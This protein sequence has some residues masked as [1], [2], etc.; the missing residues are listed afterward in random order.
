M[1]DIFVKVNG[2]DRLVEEMFFVKRGK[3]VELKAVKVNGTIFKAL[4]LDF[5]S[6]N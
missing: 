3:F 1:T 4:N 2:I 6:E 5:W